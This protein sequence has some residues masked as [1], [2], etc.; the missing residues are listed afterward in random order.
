[1]QRYAV[2]PFGRGWF[3][4]WQ[5]SLQQASDGTITIFG[6]N[7]SRRVFQPDT[8]GGYFKQPGDHGALAP[9]GGGAFILTE[10]TGVLYYYRS[11]GKLGY[12][13]DLNQNRI[14]LGY[15]GNLLTSLSHSSGQSIQIGYNAAGRVQT[16]TDSFNR[17]TILSYDVSNE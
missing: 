11:D 4:S 2:G 10:K 3:H 5:Y 13:E 8:R 14:T 9:A 1:S 7:L 6:P 16:V 12:M 17:Q 15:T